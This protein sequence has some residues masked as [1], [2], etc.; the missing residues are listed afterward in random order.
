MP[1]QNFR[2]FDSESDCIICKTSKILPLYINCGH[3]FCGSCLCSWINHLAIQRSPS[4][5]PTCKQVVHWIQKLGDPPPS[6]RY[7]ISFYGYNRERANQFGVGA[8]VCSDEV[9]EPR[10]L[11]EVRQIED[12]E[13]ERIL[14]AQHE[15]I[16][17]RRAQRQA[18]RARRERIMANRAARFAAERES[19]IMARNQRIASYRAARARLFAERENQDN[20][21][22]SQGRQRD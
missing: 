10:T 11:D 14:R 5:C 21:Q 6:P 8:E 1:Q 19:V 15:M 2:I 3:C 16:I 22:H 13:P 17:R 12:F 7:L 9:I 4:T 18:N 20:F